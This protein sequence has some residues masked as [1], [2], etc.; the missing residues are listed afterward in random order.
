MLGHRTTETP[1]VQ[2]PSAAIFVGVAGLSKCMT[3]GSFI[4]GFVGAH[5]V[6]L[7]AS[8]VFPWYVI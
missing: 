4:Q 8:S 3:A 2:P 7:I 5:I 6:W 1:R